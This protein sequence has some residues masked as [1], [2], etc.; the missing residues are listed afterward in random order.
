MSEKWEKFCACQLTEAVIQRP[1]CI[2]YNLFCAFL[3]IGMLYLQPDSV[4]Q[5]RFITRVM[6]WKIYLLRVW[7]LVL[8]KLSCCSPTKIIMKERKMLEEIIYLIIR[9]ITSTS[10]VSRVSMEQCRFSD[11]PF[12]KFDY[13]WL[14]VECDWF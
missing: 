11:L 2:F 13:Q 9:T 5:Y 12:W 6:E 14:V 10:S 7:E 3:S 4:K 8:L 1:I